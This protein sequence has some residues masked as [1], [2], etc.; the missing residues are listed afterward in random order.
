MKRTPRDEYLERA[1]CLPGQEV[2]RLLSRM[3][4][5]LRRRLEEDRLSP[6]EV[7]ALQLEIDDDDLNEWRARMSELQATLPPDLSD[8]ARI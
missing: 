7:I 3:R 2:E 8:T 5:K 1:R 4:G 6:L